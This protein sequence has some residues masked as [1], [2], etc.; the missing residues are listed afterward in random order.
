MRSRGDSKRAL[1]TLAT[2]RFHFAKEGVRV[3]L[4]P[5]NAATTADVNSLPLHGYGDSCP[6]AAQWLARDGAGLLSSVKRLRGERGRWGSI[7]HLRTATICW[8]RG[9]EIGGGSGLARRSGRIDW[10][11]PSTAAATAAATA[12][13]ASAAVTAAAGEQDERHQGNDH[14]PTAWADEAKRSCHPRTSLSGRYMVAVWLRVALR[15]YYR[16]SKY[17]SFNRPPSHPAKGPYQGCEAG[18]WRGESI[19]R[20]RGGARA[21]FGGVSCSHTEC[22]DGRQSRL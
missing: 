3:T 13:T 12:T 14:E 7:R 15:S 20:E 9:R 17:V 21:L 22:A 4:H 11:H 16:Q 19:A 6:H 8:R 1:G 5:G 18:A 2:L 10:H